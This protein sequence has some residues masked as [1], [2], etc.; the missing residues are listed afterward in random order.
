MKSLLAQ[1]AMRHFEKDEN[2]NKLQVREDTKW[3]QTGILVVEKSNNASFQPTLKHLFLL[4]LAFVGFTCLMVLH[5][6]TLTEN[7]SQ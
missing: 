4:E 6:S 1:R 5:L 7:S 2:L 3:Q